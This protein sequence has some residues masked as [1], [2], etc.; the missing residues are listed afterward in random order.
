MDV[1]DLQLAVAADS[2]AASSYQLMSSAAV[3]ERH[4]GRNLRVGPK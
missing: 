4:L 3:V 2:L 1:D